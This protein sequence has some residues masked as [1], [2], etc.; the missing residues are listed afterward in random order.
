MEDFEVKTL[1]GMGVDSG[2]RQVLLRPL[3]TT[4]PWYIK[5]SSGFL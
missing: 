2:T 3:P 5:A 4:A 1:L